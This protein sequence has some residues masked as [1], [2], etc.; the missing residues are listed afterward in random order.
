MF[1]Q[2]IQFIRDLFCWF[3][4]NARQLDQA[5]RMRSSEMLLHLTMQQRTVF[6][7]ARYVAKELGY[8]SIKDIK[9][10]DF[11]ISGFLYSKSFTGIEANVVTNALDPEATNKKLTTLILA[12]EVYKGGLNLTDIR[13]LPTLAEYAGYKRPY[14]LEQQVG[15]VLNDLVSKRSGSRS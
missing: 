10:F 4:I 3:D 11:I 13:K 12:Y 1:A 2:F 7:T 8:T 6:L 9:F 15:R 5:R 14:N